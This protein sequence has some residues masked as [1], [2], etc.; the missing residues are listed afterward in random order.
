MAVE[1]R[2]LVTLCILTSCRFSSI[3]LASFPM[4]K[5]PSAFSKAENAART[6]KKISIEIESDM[7]E[8]LILKVP[9]SEKGQRLSN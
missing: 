4:Y 5:T 2:R 6:N 1:G 9:S 8:N 3:F 7:I